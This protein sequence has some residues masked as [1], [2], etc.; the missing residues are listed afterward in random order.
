MKRDPYYPDI[1][2]QLIADAR[3]ALGDYELAVEAL[4]ARL[5]RSPNS[6]TAHALL[7]SCYGM[8]G[9]PE[10]CQKEWAETLRLSPGFSMERRGGCCRS[11]TRSISS[12][13]WRGCARAAWRSRHRAPLLPGL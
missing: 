9:R 6:E 2:L 12:G 4:E 11:V 8:L 3:Y 1:T 5:K 7:A 10:D 13:G